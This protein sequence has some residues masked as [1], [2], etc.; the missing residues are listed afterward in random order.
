[1]KSVMSFRQYITN[2]LGICCFLSVRHMVDSTTCLTL[3]N[4]QIPIYRCG[5]G[6][7][8]Y[9]QLMVYL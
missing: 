1:M 4:Q 9:H 5:N 8:L 3:K 7:L 2:G 6:S